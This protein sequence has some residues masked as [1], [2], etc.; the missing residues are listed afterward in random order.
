MR[1][2]TLPFM[3]VRSVRALPFFAAPP[4]QQSI[5]AELNK[6]L[7]DFPVVPERI[8]DATDAPLI[9]LVFNQPDNLGAPA[10]ACAKTVSG[11]STT[12]TMRMLDPPS[13][14]GLKFLC[15]GDSSASQKFDLLLRVG[16]R[17][18]A[19]IHPENFGGSECGFV[20]V[21]GLGAIANGEH[22]GP[23]DPPS[24]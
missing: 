19:V 5:R 22:G 15:S 6:R 7:T 4:F 8:D 17:P 14:S 1:I 2:S 20:E 16:P 9:G 23:S 3:M 13:V 18:T 10:T 12:R 21:D 11:S 24:P